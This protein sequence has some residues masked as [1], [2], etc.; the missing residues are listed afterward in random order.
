MKMK[1]EDFKKRVN[2]LLAEERQNPSCLWFLSYA[3]D[4]GSKGCIFIEAH[5]MVEA[6]YLAKH[7]K[8][9]PGGEVCGTSVPP[10]HAPAKEWH[11]RLL[12]REQLAEATGEEVH[13]IK[14]WNELEERE[15]NATKPQ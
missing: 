8:L 9:S 14:E 3:D 5:G 13:S 1:P 12:T 10:E 4:T 11:N 2:K 7:R 15:K 6:V